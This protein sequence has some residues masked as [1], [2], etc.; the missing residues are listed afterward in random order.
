MMNN[1]SFNNNIRDNLNI[2]II[3]LIILIFSFYE[4]LLN[5]K[6]TVILCAD[7]LKQKL[8]PI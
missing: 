8:E 3:L 1:Y 2:E 4:Q 5:N 6:T 7:I